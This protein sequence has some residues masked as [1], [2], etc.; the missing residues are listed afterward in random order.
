MTQKIALGAELRVPKTFI[1]CSSPATGS[2][3][4]FA[5]HYRADPAWKFFEL[6]TGH[7][8]MLLMPERVAELLQK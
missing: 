6:P 4:Q 3:D 5:A 8:A 2:F 7:D 1:Y